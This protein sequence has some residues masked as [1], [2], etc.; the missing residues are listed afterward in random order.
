MGPLPYYILYMLPLHF[1]PLANFAL[2]LQL[3]QTLD[4]SLPGAMDT[5]KVAATTAW[6][7]HELISNMKLHIIH[8]EPTHLR[9]LEIRVW[10]R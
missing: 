1:V 6:T 2:S 3:L 7:T 10:R 5:I 4:L 8:V 9:I